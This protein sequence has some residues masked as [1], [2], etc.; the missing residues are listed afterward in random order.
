MTVHALLMGLPLC[1][2]SRKVPA[3][4]PEDH[5]WVY[6]QE[7]RDVT[8]EVCKRMLRKLGIV[9]DRSAG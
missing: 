7:H 3:D 9:G 6:T 8:C 1:G 2:F 5:K 4:W